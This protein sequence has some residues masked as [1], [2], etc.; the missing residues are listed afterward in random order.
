MR[1]TI[2][3]DDGSTGSRHVVVG[4]DSFGSGDGGRGGSGQMS[5]P[6]ANCVSAVPDMASG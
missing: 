2:R 4:F 5:S 1:W 3:S 6:R